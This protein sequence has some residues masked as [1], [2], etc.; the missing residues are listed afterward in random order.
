MLVPVIGLVQAGEQAMADRYT[1][2]PMIG[3]VVAAVWWAGEA[4][5]RWSPARA[6]RAAGTTAALAVV[7]LFILTRQQVSYWQNTLTLFG[8][9]AD[10][11]ADNASAQFGIA[12][13]LLEQDQDRKAMVRLRVAVAIDPSYSRA[14]YILGQLLRMEGQFKASAEQYQAALQSNQSDIRALVNYAGVLPLLGRPKEAIECLT[15]ALQLEPDS[16]EAL[17][18]LAWILATSSEPMLRDG[19]KAVRCGK[20]ACELS[21]FKQAAF[22]GTLGAAYAE[23][24][25]FPKA[26][27]TAQRAIEVAN[28]TGE[29]ELSTRNQQLLGLYRTG[30]AYREKAAR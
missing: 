13:G 10:V 5:E 18:N 12:M 27:A 19:A 14:H 11:T 29:S 9:A 6:A 22:I 4:L 8:H 20:R 30:K 1:Y 16:V 15:R 21:Q 17:N 28:K 26:I 2:L 7:T 24:G 25:E 3:L 23:A